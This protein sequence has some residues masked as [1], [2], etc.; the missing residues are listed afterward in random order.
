MDLHIRPLDTGSDADLAQ[1]N[2]LV[3]A[4]DTDLFGGCE[5]CTVE[6]KR[7]AY[8][9]TAYWRSQR[10]GAFAELMEGG[11]SL[12]GIAGLQIPLEEN[13]ETVFVSFTIHPAFRGQGIGTALVEQAVLPAVRE[14]GRTLI[15]AWGE[16]PADGDP[17]DPALP[18]NRIAARLGISRRNIGVCRALPLP[19]DPALLDALEA[20]AAERLGEHRIEL[21]EDACPEEH[22]PAYGA[23]LRQLDLDDPDEDMEYEA[24]D[25]T[26][27][28]IR[29]MERRRRES[30]TRALIA[31]AI[32]P[33]GEIV[34]NSEIH[35]QE[36]DGQPPATVAWQ[37]NTL[38]MPAHRGH[39]L[40]LAMKVATHRRLTEKVP[41]ARSLV[42][43]NS[44]VNPWM[45]SLNERF[46]YRVL[47]R[48]IAYQGRIED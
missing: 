47:F 43:W 42:T 22:L 13:L 31:V 30:G 4:W 40:G 39:R 44:H 20:E 23:L 18:W 29:T 26:P 24:A 19:V 2:A 33:G 14:S 36:A 32:A 3:A 25:Y 34:G 11:S 6:Q 15:S 28:R 12:V 5:P 9:D 17:D 27:G 37:E 48:E 21:W 45:I 1:A 7:A 41:A 8:T 35:W 38:V 46:G 16:I 10:F